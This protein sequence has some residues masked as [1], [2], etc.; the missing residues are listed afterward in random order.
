MTICEIA[1]VFNVSPMTVSNALNNKPGVARGKAE[2]IRE[3]AAKM[4]YQPSYLARSLQNGRSRTVGLCLREMPSDPWSGML[5]QKIQARLYENDLYLNTIVTPS[6][7]LSEME[8]MKREKWALDFFAGIKTGAVLI[9]PLDMA[10]FSSLSDALRKHCHV[11]AFDSLDTLPITH[12]RLDLAEGCRLAISLLQENG[13]R[14]IGYIGRN[15]FE[16]KC[17]SENTRYC[18]IR[19]LARQA[20]MKFCLEWSI[21]AENSKDE[22]SALIASGHPLPSAFFCHSDNFALLAIK[23][24][25]E[26]GLRVPQDISIIGFDDQPV[27]QLATPDITSIGFDLDAYVDH[28]VRFVLDAVEN[29]GRNRENGPMSYLAAPRLMMRHSVGSSCCRCR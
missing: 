12:L 17:P 15:W 26:H 4:G 9:G 2:S 24:F 23:V 14:S 5:I 25:S 18:R 13:H 10:R 27:A 1:K 21:S 28:L 8:Q 7:G 19:Q 3:Y 20:G 6:A 22:L 11:I 16:E 29:P